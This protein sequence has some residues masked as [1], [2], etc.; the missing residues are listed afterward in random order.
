[1]DGEP[2]RQKLAIS[3]MPLVGPGETTPAAFMASLTTLRESFRAQNMVTSTSAVG[4]LKGTLF[5]CSAEL[6]LGH[7]YIHFPGE[8]FLLSYLV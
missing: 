2:F 1:M 4:E 6:F 7:A 8:R 3:C 5:L